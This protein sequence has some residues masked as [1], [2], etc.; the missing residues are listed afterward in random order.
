MSLNAL[1]WAIRKDL[2][3]AQKMVLLML[4]NHVANDDAARV[5]RHALARVC[6]LDI[7]ETTRALY[8][9]EK[10]GLVSIDCRAGELDRYTLLMGVHP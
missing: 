6:G 9:L 8:A 5:E 10:A 4:A 3:C 1:D 7:I 2:P